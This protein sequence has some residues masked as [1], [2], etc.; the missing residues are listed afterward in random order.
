MLN[1]VNWK[2]LADQLNLQDQVAAIQDICNREIDIRPCYF[3]E[4]VSRYI[5][6]QPEESCDNSRRKIV[7]ALEELG[8]VN[9]ASHLRGLKLG[10]SVYMYVGISVP[11]SWFRHSL[12]R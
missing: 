8:F 12:L 11:F 6:S 5:Q 10:E 7:T 3:R 9:E 4:V 1:D 2:T